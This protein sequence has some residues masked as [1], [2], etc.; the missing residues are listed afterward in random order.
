MRVIAVDDE[1]MALEDFLYQVEKVPE[2]KNAKVDVFT[3]VK[4]AL[5]FMKK[6]V[7]DIAFLDIN[8]GVLN[9]L[10]LAGAFK[11]INPKCE[12]I[13]L[14]GYSEYALD[15]F[16]VKAFGY[17]LKPISTQDLQKE[18]QDYLKTK[19]NKK[20]NFR[21][22]CFG[23]FAFFAN[24]KVLV[25]EREKTQELLAYLIDQKGAFVNLQELCEE[26]WEGRV[27]TYSLRSQLRNH[28]YFLK[29]ALGEVGGENI[30][31]KKR[32]ALAVDVN[33]FSC[34]YYA[35]LAK[36]KHAM[37]SF[38]GEYMYSYSWGEETVAR[39]VELAHK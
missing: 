30:L 34:D 32:N 27:N 31:L 13:F 19:G 3:S 24:E 15:A 28:I 14:T 25:F 35:F 29:T 38:K 37:D 17:L 22:Q 33:L 23:R 4:K 36:D 1:K 26:L 10:E 8:M 6:E 18:I 12:I 5:E 21:A 9:G 7:I 39:L 16:K 11:E 2:L 20:K